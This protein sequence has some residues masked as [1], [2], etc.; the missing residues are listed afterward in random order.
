MVFHKWK[1]SIKHTAKVYGA[2]DDE[3]RTSIAHS[4][5]G[6]IEGDVRTQIR[7]VRSSRAG[8]ER[9]T[10]R[11]TE[12]GREYCQKTVEVAYSKK[13][14]GRRAPREWQRAPGGWLACGS[15]RLRVISLSSSAAVSLLRAKTKTR[16]RVTESVA[17]TMQLGTRCTASVATLPAATGSRAP[18]SQ[19]VLKDGWRREQGGGAR[20][21]PSSPRWRGIFIFSRP[22]PCTGTPNHPP[23]TLSHRDQCHYI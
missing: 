8:R 19:G 11:H 14:E 4:G 16:M 17:S 10:K 7:R 6:I 18:R 3:K 22:H 12:K 2:K 23:T 9:E 1:T 5:I 20:A 21:C 13:G 15:V